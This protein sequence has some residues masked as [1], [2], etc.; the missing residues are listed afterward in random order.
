MVAAKRPGGETSPHASALDCRCI[1]PPD[2]ANA[3]PPYPGGEGRRAASPIQFQTTATLAPLHRRCA[4]FIE[5]ATEPGAILRSTI[6]AG[7]LRAGCSVLCSV[8]SHIRL[9]QRRGAP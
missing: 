8:G 3:R 4:N 9:E 2:L 6:T 5:H 7:V 1:S